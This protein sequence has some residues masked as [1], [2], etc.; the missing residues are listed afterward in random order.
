MRLKRKTA[1]RASL[2]AITAALTLT[3][4]TWAYL[5]D[6][7]EDVRNEF[8]ANSVTVEL[9]ESTG[10]YYDIIP[11]T[12]QKKDPRVTLSNTVDAYVFVVVDD[13]TDGLVKYDIDDGWLKLDGYNGVYYRLA[14]AGNA[15]EYPVIKNDM[16]YYDPSIGNS[17]M[18]DADG[19]LKGG[20]TLTFRAY[21]I[22]KEPFDSPQDAYEQTQPADSTLEI[23]VEYVQQTNPENPKFIAETFRTED[24]TLLQFGALRAYYPSDLYYEG[25]K[26]VFKISGSSDKDMALTF[27]FSEK[28][29][30]NETYK[31]HEFEYGFGGF[32]DTYM[33]S[34]EYPDYSSGAPN[35][36]FTL[37]G[38]YYPIVFTVK[39]VKG[40]SQFQFSGSLTELTE[41]LSEHPFILKAGVEYD[42]EYEITMKW[43]FQTIPT[44][45]C[46]V[47]KDGKEDPRDPNYPGICCMD[48]AD[49]LLG[50]TDYEDGQRIGRQLWA[51]VEISI[52]QAQ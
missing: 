5:K 26:Y 49:T 23:S 40:N 1:L 4:G 24:S 46:H 12:S 28:C 36:T 44:D 47:I 37:S 21:A 7:T 11:G 18:T 8:K 45:E 50:S 6:G 31:G 43:P 17:D 2:I 22:Q 15:K 38:D 20:L 3:A 48:R 52:R 14:E 30:E 41:T 39:Q 10:E 42:E 19:S 9:T 29:G 51:D 32:A 25:C 35:G 16:V 27:D 34:G 33:L 13:A